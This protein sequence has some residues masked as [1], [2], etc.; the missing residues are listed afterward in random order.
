[1]GANN[2]KKDNKQLP[3]SK[4][5]TMPYKRQFSSE[6]ARKTQ[7]T[8]Y[9]EHRQNTLDLEDKKLATLTEEEKAEANNNTHNL[10]VK[11][12]DVLDPKKYKPPPSPAVNDSVLPSTHDNDN[13]FVNRK[14]SIKE[15]E[16][17]DDEG[18]DS[19]ND[20]QLLQL[21][22]NTERAISPGSNVLINDTHSDDNK[23][24]KLDDKNN[25]NK[26][27]IPSA[28]SLIKQTSNHDRIASNP[29]DGN[30]ISNINA[31]NNG[32]DVLLWGYCELTRKQL[33]ED[34]A[35]F[36]TWSHPTDGFVHSWAIFDG[37]GGYETALYS[38][39]H[40]LKY[41][42][43]YH[44]TRKNMELNKWKS[45]MKEIFVKFDEHIGNL[46]IRGGSTV[47]VVLLI[48]KHIICANAGDARAIMSK[49]N[50]KAVELSFDHTPMDDYD[51]LIKIAK[52]KENYKKISKFFRLNPKHE[53]YSDVQKLSPSEIKKAPFISREQDKSRLL[54]TIGVARGFGDFSLTVFGFRSIK[55]KPYLT[56][57]PYVIIKELNANDQ[58]DTDIMAIACYGVF[59]VMT[60]Q[61]VIDIL[62]KEI[63]YRKKKNDKTDVN[64]KDL[65]MDDANLNI[66]MNQIDRA[67]GFLGLK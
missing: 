1:M 8:T 59:D 12:P 64:D 18:S 57:E 7:N 13:V 10:K 65:Y 66:D 54:G 34:Q 47:V 38:A 3:P 9:S 4:P 35:A 16:A 45:L 58:L 29:I 36:L 48:G 55:L 24:D 22:S 40:F 21:K 19:M 27:D 37:H 32:T 31:N 52:L 39:Q 28:G 60:N 17:L 44:L 62:R 2:S 56:A 46:N 25:Y 53:T 63:Y 49:D 33:D 20:A 50:G 51:R 23:T 42:Q 15:T 41:V 14:E 6:A 11:K 5:K 43:K 30:K 67:C 26:M 61:E